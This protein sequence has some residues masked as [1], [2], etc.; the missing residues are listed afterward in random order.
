MEVDASKTDISFTI[1]FCNWNRWF[2]RRCSWLS[3]LHCSGVLCSISIHTLRSMWC[4]TDKSFM[5]LLC[6]IFSYNCMVYICF[7]LYGVVAMV[8][9]PPINTK[10]QKF[11]LAL[12]RLSLANAVVCWSHSIIFVTVECTALKMVL[13]LRVSANFSG[14]KRF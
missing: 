10:L 4:K 5:C 1:T 3:H 6:E 14:N 13:R 2:W 7:F 9:A 11:S 8:D 12:F